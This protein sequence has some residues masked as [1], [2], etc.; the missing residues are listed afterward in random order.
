MKT[1]KYLF[2]MLLYIFMYSCSHFNQPIPLEDPDVKGYVVYVS[3]KGNEVIIDLK[4]GDGIS[5]G[6]KLDVFRENVSNLQKSVKLGEITIESVGEKSSKAVVTSITSSLRMEKGDRVKPHQ[7]LIV[8]DDSWLVSKTP[9]DGWQSDTENLDER[10]WKSSQILENTRL[11]PEMRQLIAETKARPIWH[12][13]STSREGDVFFR[14]M[15]IIDGVPV[16]ANIRIACGGKT[17]LYINNRWISKVDEWPEITDIKVKKY[18]EN[19]RN[20]I[21]IHT[22]RDYRTI[23]PPVLLL[24]LQIETDFIQNEQ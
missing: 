8:S 11:E 6:M 4:K 21:A 9:I 14:K 2:L 16:N 22:I 15:F 18:L 3:A 10:Y 20:V 19:G 7:I 1:F 5:R 17:N 12:S 13:S 24:A 23:P